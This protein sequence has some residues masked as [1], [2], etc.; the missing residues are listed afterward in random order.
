[1]LLESQIAWIYV[2][3]LKYYAK[4]GATVACGLGSLTLSLFP[5]TFPKMLHFKSV[6]RT[7]GI[8]VLCVKITEVVYLSVWMSRYAFRC[9]SRYGSETWYVCRGWTPRLLNIHSDLIKGHLEV[10]FPLKEPLTKAR[11]IIVVKDHVGVGQGQTAVKKL[12]KPLWPPIVVGRTPD[13]SYTFLWS[14]VM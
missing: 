4:P 9:A 2:S 3:Q 14:K 7:F 12:K 10:N 8:P 6:M 13:H 11:C 5:T 1:M